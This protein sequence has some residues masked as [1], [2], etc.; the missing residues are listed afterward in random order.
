MSI[1]DFEDSFLAP[2]NEVLF[3]CPFSIHQHFYQHPSASIIFYQHP[4]ETALKSCSL[5]I[6]Y[7]YLCT[8]F[9]NKQSHVATVQS[10][11]EAV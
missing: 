4:S 11:R 8:A 10:L 1:T 9:R 5:S 7:P 2:Q 6:I 3:F